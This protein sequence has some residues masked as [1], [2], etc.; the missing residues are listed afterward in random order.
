MVTV[1]VGS[2]ANVED[3]A[4][5]SS[6]ETVTKTSRGARSRDFLIFP[7]PAVGCEVKFVGEIAVVPGNILPSSYC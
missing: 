5:K 1:E 6:F 4:E 3:A 7:P 2:G